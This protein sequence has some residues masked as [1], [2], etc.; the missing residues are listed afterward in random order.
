M[1]LLECAAEDA[2]RLF[3]GRVVESFHRS[4]DR[5]FVRRRPG[6]GFA[7]SRADTTRSLQPSW[8]DIKFHLDRGV[9]RT[10]GSFAEVAIPRAGV[11]GSSGRSPSTEMRRQ[12]CR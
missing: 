8:T 9:P 1:D 10:H 4:Y 6:S 12:L 2:V 7:S 5:S 11:F 3:A